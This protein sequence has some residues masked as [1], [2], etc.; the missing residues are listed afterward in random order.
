[1]LSIAFLYD[2]FSKT[3]LQLNETKRKTLLYMKYKQNLLRKDKVWNKAS[4]KRTS[5]TEV[6][7]PDRSV[8]PSIVAKT[9]NYNI[10]SIVL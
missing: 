4:E 3:I 5:C 1:M 7:S 6:L 9:N 2:F 10:I 8:N